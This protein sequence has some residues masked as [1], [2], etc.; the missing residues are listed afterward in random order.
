M[1]MKALAR[2]AATVATVTTL[3]LSAQAETLV[4]SNVDGRV[5]VG[6]NVDPDGVQALMPD[7]WDAISWPSG[8]LKG[9]NLL[10]A[11]I[12]GMVEMDAEGKPLDP[13]DRRAAVLVGLGKNAD[14]V[15]GYVLRIMTTVPE[16][17][18]YSV[19]IPADIS[20]TRTLTDPADGPRAVSDIWT[21]EPEGGGTMEIELDYTAGARGWSAGE[22]FPFSAADPMFSRIYR[23]EQMVDLVVSE[24]LG[25]PASGT[26]RVTSDVPELAA[27]FDGSER[28]MAVMDVPVYV[29]EVSLP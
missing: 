22:S 9:A 5:L 3:S 11:L 4:G 21:I 14:V 7:G 8:P 24:G 17:D 27:L 1:L 20:R 12:D 18:P 28:I 13:P 26:Y 29:R 10:L 2:A 23:Y 16:R 25:K 19:A 15:R 6:L